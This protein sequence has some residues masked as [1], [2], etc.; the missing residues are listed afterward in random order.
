MERVNCG[1]FSVENEM[2]LRKKFA[3]NEKTGK[4]VKDIMKEL[5]RLNEFH[6]QMYFDSARQN[7]ETVKYGAILKTP[8]PSPYLD[9]KYGPDMKPEEVPVVFP[10]CLVRDSLNVLK[11]SGYEV[12]DSFYMEYVGKSMEQARQTVESIKL[13]AIC[14]PPDRPSEPTVP[15]NTNNPARTIAPRSALSMRTSTSDPTVQ[16]S[17]K[18]KKN[19]KK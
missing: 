17:V 4:Y 5:R 7:V 9:A 19:K 3:K 13:F 10:K 2:F 14:V 6:V 11:E 16:K 15:W 12:D 1:C 8:D 18:S